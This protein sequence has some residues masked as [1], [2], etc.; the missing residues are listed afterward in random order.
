MKDYKAVILA[1]GKGTRLYPITKEIPKP[2]LPINKKP[3]INYLVDLFLKTGIEDIAVLINKSFEEDFYW[4]KKRYYPDK[5]IK[6]LEEN[7]PLG[8]FGGLFHLKKWIGEDN[9]FLSNGDEIKQLNLEKMISFHDEMNALATLGLVKVQDPQNY[10]V[11]VCENDLVLNF[12]EK[13]K[14]PPCNFVSAGLYLLSA[15]IF[16]YHPG[17]T[18]SMIEKDLF[19]ILAKEKKLVG[20]KFEGEW[21]DCGTWER[22]EKAL[23]RFKEESF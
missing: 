6:I 14:L 15:D 1:G 2:L 10:G 9:F 8:T 17:L 23:Q 7:E 13:P 3:I 19:P 5:K 21:M 20:F 16:K 4:W 18:F 11:V 22:Y 12:L